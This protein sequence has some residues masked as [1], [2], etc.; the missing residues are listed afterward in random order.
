MSQ[1]ATAAELQA[2]PGAAAYVEGLADAELDVALTRASALIDGYVSTRTTLPLTTVPESLKQAAI[3]IAAW[4]L[5]SGRGFDVGAVG[6][7]AKQWHDWWL[8]WLQDVA[9]GSAPLPG[10][11]DTTTST[12]GARVSTSTPRGW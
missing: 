5:A 3:H 10:V 7:T 6:N 1:Y 2:T 11:T 9:S 8:K 4:Y 12:S